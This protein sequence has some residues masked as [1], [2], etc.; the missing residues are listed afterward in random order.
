MIN[1]IICN[2]YKIISHLGT[3]GMA[4]VWL[5]ED[6]ILNR[7]VAV[8]T[9]KI[10]SNDEEAIKRFNR[11]ANAVTTLYH[12]NIVSIYDVENEDNFYYLI[13]EYVEGMTL[14]DYMVKNP[15]IPLDTAIHIMK[16]IA[17]GL[18]HAHKNGI[19]HRDIKPQNILMDKNLTCKITDFG[20]S[21]AYGDTTLTQ[22]N[23][24]LGTVYYLSPEQAR[25]NVATAQS[26]IYSLGILMF[27]LLTG[28][29]PFKGES[30][31]AIALKHLQEDI[32]NID[33]YRSDIPKSVKNIIIKATMKN[34]NE[35]YI[36]SKELSEDLKTCLN[37]ERLNETLYTGFSALNNKNDDNYERTVIQTY[38]NSEFYNNY[39]E[40]KEKNNAYKKVYIKNED[41]LEK[42]KK[43]PILK[44]F[45]AIF[46]IISAIG[47]TAYSYNYYMNV[48]RISV[49]DLKN[50]TL[51]EAKSQILNAEL[52]V[53]EITEVANDNVKE[54]TVIS[55]D[56]SNGKKVAKGSVINLKVSSGKN[57]IDMPNY[58]GMT[59]LQVRNAIEKLGFKNVTYEKANSDEYEEGKVMYQ[60]ID[61]GKKV[62]PKDTSLVI[63]ISTGAKEILIPNFIGKTL[64][65]TYSL[66]EKLGVKIR[67]S[68]NEYSS[69]YKENTIISQSQSENSKLKKGDEISVVVSKGENPATS[70]VTVTNFVEKDVE[71]LKTWAEK[72]DLILKITY[73]ESNIPS[74][75]VI[76]QSPK[77]GT[78]KKGSSISVTVAR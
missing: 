61:S 43:S 63:K 70:N 24:M 41:E 45:I 16:Q 53:G 23:Q 50:L 33:K 66:A 72:N 36:S 52:V 68:A 57:T 46:L 58:L 3:G 64:N 51:E 11:E 15:N 76:S 21:R 13:L 8:K 37:Y 59:E 38:S 49:P 30:A 56:P 48:S 10:D 26:D 20:I 6:T 54:N 9:F 55:S 44:I 1:N 67:V 4:T 19:I 31:V 73:K 69:E 65:E 32:P 29:I 78:I 71:S 34:P 47:I 40:S 14:K 17:E 22:T 39:N 7:K 77:N 5:A 60:S 2:R 27:E 75:T 12:N 25:G 18:S 62:N 35:R 74:G 42:K 28:K